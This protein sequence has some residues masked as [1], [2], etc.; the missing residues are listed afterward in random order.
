MVDA[1]EQEQRHL[2]ARLPH[3]VAQRLSRRLGHND[4]DGALHQQRRRAV[5]VHVG[6]GRE[7]TTKGQKL[8]L[9]GMG[10]DGSVMII[11]GATGQMTVLDRAQRTGMTMTREQISRC[12]RCPQA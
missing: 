3:P 8:R 9:E 11:D 5:G 1:G 4:V 2:C 7:Q 12:R 6:A 10:K